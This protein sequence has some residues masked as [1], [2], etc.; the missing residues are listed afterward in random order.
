MIKPLG[1]RILVQIRKFE[2]TTKN[3]IIL[4]SS[5]DKNIKIG[6]VIEGNNGDIKKGDKIIINNNSG[7]EINYKDERYLIVE[8]DDV[9][10]KIE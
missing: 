9:L 7:N 5:E 8:Q 3:G 4:S 1:K 10:A 6:E 2:E